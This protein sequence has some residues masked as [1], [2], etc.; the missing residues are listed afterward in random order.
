M[1]SLST[2]ALAFFDHALFPSVRSLQRSHGGLF[3]SMDRVMAESSRRQREFLSD[4]NIPEGQSHGQSYS[5]SSSTIQTGSDAPVTQRSEAWRDA[6]GKSCRAHTVPSAT[7][8]WRKPT[9]T[10]RPHAAC[11]T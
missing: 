10:A 6:D 7:K 4:F 5:Y 11:G 9:T 1:G 8:L 3:A 2:M